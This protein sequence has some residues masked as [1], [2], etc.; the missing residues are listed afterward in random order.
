MMVRK[1]LT[2]VLVVGSLM[3]AAAAQGSQ[4]SRPGEAAPQRQGRPTAIGGGGMPGGMAGHGMMGQGPG[5]MGHSRMMHRM[6][7]RHQEMMR[8]MSRMRAE[9]R[10]MERATTPAAR[11]RDMEAMRAGSW[12]RCMAP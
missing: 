9:M 8:L 10:A 5:Q 11:R 7:A 6:L 1:G 2:A 3:L 12:T 4:A